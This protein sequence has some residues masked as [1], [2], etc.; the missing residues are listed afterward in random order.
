[1]FALFRGG[2]Q[3]PPDCLALAMELQWQPGAPDAAAAA[4]AIE[5][6]KSRGVRRVRHGSL[7]PLGPVPGWW[8]GTWAD[9]GLGRRDAALLGYDT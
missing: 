6:P 7:E 5:S 3:P 2:P 1:M 9:L 8:I 4:A